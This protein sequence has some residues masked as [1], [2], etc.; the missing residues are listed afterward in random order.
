[1][2]GLIVSSSGG[3]QD[4]INFSFRGCCCSSIFKLIIAAKLVVKLIVKLV[5]KLVV[6]LGGLDDHSLGCRSPNCNGNT[7]KLLW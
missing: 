7:W 5:I 4:V 2:V 3:G 1:M 6:K